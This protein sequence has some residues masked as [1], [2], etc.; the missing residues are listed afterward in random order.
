MRGPGTTAGAKTGA[1][2]LE[3]GQRTEAETGPRKAKGRGAAG[4]LKRHA[5]VWSGTNVVPAAHGNH[6]ASGEAVGALP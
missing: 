6:E 1:C 3:A 5:L 2:E 4:V